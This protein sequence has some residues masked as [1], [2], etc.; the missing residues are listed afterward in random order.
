MSVQ[1]VDTVGQSITIGWTRP[2]LALRALYQ[3]DR[4]RDFL[5][6]SNEDRANPALVELM[7]KHLV[8]EVKVR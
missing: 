3:I 7:Q 1:S 6:L 4:G 8:L 5:G 2:E